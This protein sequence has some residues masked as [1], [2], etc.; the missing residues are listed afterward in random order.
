[1]LFRSSEAAGTDELAAAS[2]EGSAEPT[3]A[4]LAASAASVAEV[5]E[6]TVDVSAEPSPSTYGA[7]SYVGDEPPAGFDIKGNEDSMKFHTPE[8]RYYGQ[9]IAEVWFDSAAAA[10]AA[11]FTNAVREQPEEDAK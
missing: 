7:G 8:S 9:T 4:E 1:M 3:N 6:P 5:L 2:V 10:E 11:G